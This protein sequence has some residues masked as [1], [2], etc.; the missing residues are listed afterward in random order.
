MARTTHNAETAKL[1][2]QMLNSDA[3]T[4][5]SA[6]KFHDASGKSQ[7]QTQ[8]NHCSGSVGLT[9]GQDCTPNQSPP[10]QSGAHGPGDTEPE[11]GEPP[12]NIWNLKLRSPRTPVRERGT[13]PPYLDYSRTRPTRS[14]CEPTTPTPL[15]RSQRTKPL[16]VLGLD[17]AALER[18][19]HTG[20]HEPEDSEE[21]VV[22]E[23]KRE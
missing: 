17:A 13:M 9:D 12:L 2:K 22:D 11:C 16:S 15:P 21:V 14:G 10:F 18:W 1:L 5:S 23:G 7:T 20:S 6:S 4:P 19:F 8:L 3:N